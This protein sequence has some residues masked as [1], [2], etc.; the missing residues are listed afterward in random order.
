MTFTVD[1]AR[2]KRDPRYA[3]WAKSHKGVKLEAIRDKGTGVFLSPADLVRQE[4][5]KALLCLTTY[6]NLQTHFPFTK[7][8]ALSVT[9]K[10]AS[11]SLTD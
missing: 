8:Y 1:E 4:A 2:A 9:G 7:T 5:M 11:S 3:A 6:Y 10:V